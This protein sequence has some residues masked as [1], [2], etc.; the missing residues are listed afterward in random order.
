MLF[1]IVEPEEVGRCRGCFQLYPINEMDGQLCWD[2]RGVQDDKDIDHRAD[3][4]E[5][6]EFNGIDATT[7]TN[8][9]S[10]ARL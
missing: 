2:C 10:T 1:E 6:G 9:E 3:G 4:A 5:C 7:E 8:K